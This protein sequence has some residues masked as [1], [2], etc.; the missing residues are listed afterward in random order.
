[1]PIVPAVW[2][3]AT[4]RCGVTKYFM[5]GGSVRDAVHAHYNGKAFAPPR[6]IDILTTAP[7]GEAMLRI[8]SLDRGRMGS[9]GSSGMSAPY[10]NYA[11]GTTTYGILDMSSV[12]HKGTLEAPKFIPGRRRRP[13]CRIWQQPRQVGQQS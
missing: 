7:P 13:V 5:H 3:P 9:H 6:D 1:M 4:Q 12:A 10:R 8:W 11:W 2:M